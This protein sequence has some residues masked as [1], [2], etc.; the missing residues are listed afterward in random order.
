[1]AVR[2]QARDQ[3]F[4]QPFAPFALSGHASVHG[5]NPRTYDRNG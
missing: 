3:V 2:Q 1:M 5:D 4:G